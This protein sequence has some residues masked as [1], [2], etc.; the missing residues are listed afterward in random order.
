MT[1]KDTIDSYRRRR[2]QLM[3]IILGAVVLI[4][5]TIGIILVASSLKGGGIALFSSKTPTS[6]ITPTITDTLPPSETPTITE[7]PTETPTITPSEPYDYVVQEGDSLYKIVADRGLGEDGIVIILIMN[8]YQP[9]NEDR[10][11]IDPITQTIYVGQTIKLPPPNYPLP[12]ATPWPTDAVPGTRVN[13]FVL[14]GDSLGGIAAKMN[15]TITAIVNANKDILT[16]AEN[17]V[18]YPG[19]VLVVPVNLVTPVPTQTPT[20]EV[21]ATASPTETPTPT[22]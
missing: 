3:P 21:T 9:A 13:Y 15:S 22:P 4:L 7:T 2:N 1:I 17:S 11:G 6:S 18:L 14:P 12:T 8:P 20:V 16:D 10:P 5:V 19:W